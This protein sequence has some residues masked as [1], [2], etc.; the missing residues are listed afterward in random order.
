[1]LLVLTLFAKSSIISWMYV[2]CFLDQ[3]QVWSIIFTLQTG[4]S[5]IQAMEGQQQRSSIIG[6]VLQSAHSTSTKQ[7][8][9]WEC[10]VH[11]DWDSARAHAHLYLQWQCTALPLLVIFLGSLSFSGAL[12]PVCRHSFAPFTNLVG[13]L[14]PINL[15]GSW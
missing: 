2:S 6:P 14:T 12:M 15:Q 9:S 10:S 4:D 11:Q 7:L 5:D 13:M 8:P 3:S 1:M